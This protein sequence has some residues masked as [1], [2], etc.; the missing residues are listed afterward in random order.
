MKIL[1][2][3]TLPMLEHFSPAFNITT[4]ENK[5]SLAQH[6]RSHDILLCRS[7]LRVTQ[8]L[9]EDS[10]IQ[11]VATA[12][13]G[14]DHI[15]TAYLTQQN[16][17]LLDTKGCNAHAVADYVTCTLAYLNKHHYI[18]G[19]RA[20]I[21]GMGEVG[22]RVAHRL[23]LLGFEIHAYDPL[24]THFHSASIQD[25]QQCHL[26]CIHANLHDTPPHASRDLL[27]HAFLAHLKPGTILIN[28]A[29]GRIINEE[30]LLQHRHAL[31][32]CT[33]VYENEPE[34]RAEIIDYATLCTPHIAGHSIEAKANAVIHLI[35]AL[36]QY[37]DK[38]LSENLSYL[39]SLCIEPKP[40][41][42][43]DDYLLRLYDP[44]IESKSLKKAKNKTEAFLRLRQSHQ[45]RHDQDLRKTPISALE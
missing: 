9:L 29:R 28:A 17:P 12:S 33:D 26:I 15:D 13:S 35:R 10:S 42:T 5:A 37:Y 34:I 38:P 41:E 21:I 45:F 25:I 31:V 6:L 24:K 2:D 43:R 4:Y 14:V 8:G 20:G 19:P 3:S 1:A 27:N 16:I 11:C 7:T 44:S 40:Q 30:A 23:R 39:P 36:H 32:Y 18:Q 22:T